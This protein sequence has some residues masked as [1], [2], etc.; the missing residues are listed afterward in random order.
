MLRTQVP[1]N[2]PAWWL[3]IIP[4]LVIL[5]IAIIVLIVNHLVHTKQ[6]ETIYSKVNRRRESREDQTLTSWIE[7]KDLLYWL[8]IICLGTISLFTFRYKN[9][10]EVIS[11]WGFA[12]TI[13]SII[14]AVVAIGF[15][16]FQTLSSNLSSEKITVSAEKIEEATLNLDSKTLSESSRIMNEAATLLKEKMFII[17]DK[18]NSI[19]NAQEAMNEIAATGIGQIYNSNNKLDSDSEINIENFVDNVLPYLPSFPQL[20]VYT[21]FKVT[22]NDIEITPKLRDEFTK[23]LSNYELENDKKHM[24]EDFVSG[25]NMGSHGATDSFIKSLGVAKQ[26]IELSSQEKEAILNKCS[27]SL[28]SEYI[29]LVDKFVETIKMENTDNEE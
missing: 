20:F 22:M 27:K 10:T 14:L 25:A 28:E 9:A 17:E 18:L 29:N 8:L 1:I 12:G 15:T 11:H 4:V 26:F 19:N 16:L 23:T 3:I 21:H 5:L 13:V 7:K 24:A 6:K 2:I